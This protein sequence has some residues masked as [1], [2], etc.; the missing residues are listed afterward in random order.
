[1]YKTSTYSSSCLHPYT[2]AFITKRSFEDKGTFTSSRR[3][4]TATSSSSKEWSDI[5]SHSIQI[6]PHLLASCRLDFLVSRSRTLSHEFVAMTLH[7]ENKPLPR[8]Y[9]RAKF[10]F[11]ALPGSLDLQ[12]DALAA[13]LKTNFTSCSSH[14]PRRG[15]DHSRSPDGS[16][17]C[18]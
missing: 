1:M 17:V 8:S 14:C 16:P 9:L 15:P 11:L 6:T 18:I 7:S 12:N 10:N 13:T 4:S 3:P 5:P 2:K